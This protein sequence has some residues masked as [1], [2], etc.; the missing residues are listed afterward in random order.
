MC[1][2]PE[3]RGAVLAAALMLTGCPLGFEANGLRDCDAGFADDAMTTDEGTAIDARQPFDAEADDGS[4][5]ASAP[6]AEAIDLD[7]NWVRPTEAGV[8]MPHRRQDPGDAHA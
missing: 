4:L 3:L 1:L 7:P 8:D 5:D 2:A 6:D